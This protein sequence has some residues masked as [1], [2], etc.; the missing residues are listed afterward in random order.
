M[1]DYSIAFIS[2]EA[3]TRS[4][5]NELLTEKW[6]GSFKVASSIN[7]KRLE[8][9]K[10]DL[11]LI[12]TSKNFES[13][14]DLNDFCKNT[15]MKK[16]IIFHSENNLDKLKRHLKNQ[17]DI[18]IFRKVERI[19]SREFFKNQLSEIIKV[20]N[21]SSQQSFMDLG[22]VENSIS[23]DLILLGAS[24]G[25]PEALKQIIG[26][27]K[28]NM[29]PIL[30]VLHMQPEF[31][32]RYCERLQ[33]ITKLKVKRFIGH[34][35]VVPN[36][37]YIADGLN[38]MEI[39]KTGSDYFLNR[40]TDEKVKGHCP[41]VDVLFNS[42]ARIKKS[43][44]LAILLTGMGSDGAEGLNSLKNSGAFTVTQNQE[45]SEVYGMP[46][47]ALE[48]GAANCVLSLEQITKIL[49]LQEN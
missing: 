7:S 13:F 39:S 16:I 3:V 20:F 26:E 38:H 43:N 45:T 11:C 8:N 21:P 22:K 28:P 10:I 19:S 14:N 12:D 17:K 44:L 49:S 15:G 29:P 30:L 37:I 9:F 40:G 46:K 27:L 32:V 5:A 34:E 25:G 35:K 33:R 42:A 36:S 4:Y 6:L 41:S 31:M 1:S 2:N 48:I 47:A 18:I 24:T 23:Y